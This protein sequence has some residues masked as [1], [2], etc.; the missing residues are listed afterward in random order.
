MA[1][2]VVSTSQVWRPLKIGG[3]GF[4]TKIAS[5]ADGT[6]I[7]RTDTY[8]GYIRRPNDT[9]WTQFKTAYSMPSA[10]VYYASGTSQTSFG[11]YDVAIATTNNDIMYMVSD[12]RPYKSTNGGATW[13]E[14][15]N[16]F[17]TQ[18]DSQMD[19]DA[20][21]GY[22]ARLCSPFMA[23]DPINADV[24][25]LGNGK[26]LY[27][28]LDGGANWAACTG[29]LDATNNYPGVAAVLVDPS[30]STT[31]GRK[32]VVYCWVYGRG[33]YQ[34]TDGG[35]NFSLMGI[36]G[37]CYPDNPASTGSSEGAGGIWNPRDA[38][39]SADG[40]ILV[41][42]QADLWRYRAGA[43]EKQS[44][45]LD[46]VHLAI[47]PFDSNRAIVQDNQNWLREC[48]N[49]NAATMT[50]GSPVNGN[51]NINGTDQPWASYGAE[52]NV[53][54]ANFTFSKTEEDKI[55]AVGGTHCYQVDVPR[56]FTSIEWVVF[57]SG[58]ENLIGIQVRKFPGNKHIY[59]T[60][61]DRGL[62]V[63]GNPEAY[64]Y[65]SSPPINEDARG[66]PLKWGS[67]AAAPDDNSDI[68][69]GL[70]YFG[71]SDCQ[72]GISYDQGKTWT[73]LNL[74]PIWYFMGPPYGTGWNQIATTSGSPTVTISAGAHGLTAGVS[75]VTFVKATAFAGIDLLGKRYL[76]ASTPDANTF[77]ITYATNASSTVA[78]GGGNLLYTTFHES[79]K[80][81]CVDGS[82]IVT[83][84]L[85]NQSEMF[86][87]GGKITI[88]NTTS[89]G[90][91]NLN[92]RQT[93]L[94]ASGNTITFAP[95]GT[96]NATVTNGGGSNFGYYLDWNGGAAPYYTQAVCSTETNWVMYGGATRLP[97]H[98][99]TDAGATWTACTFPTELSDEGWHFNAY[100]QRN[101][102]DSYPNT[103]G[104]F[105]AYHK[106]GGTYRSTDGGANW[107]LRSSE[108]FS[109]HSAGN[110][111]A[112]L[113]CVP[114]QSGHLFW[115]CGSISGGSGGYAGYQIDGRGMFS[116]DGGTTW[117]FIGVAT[118]GGADPGT[119]E[120]GEVNWISIGAVK[121]GS[122]YPTIWMSAWV[123]G[124]YG[125]YYCTDASPTTTGKWTW[126]S[127][128]A[129][130]MGSMEFI[131]G[132]QA[133]P[134]VWHTCYMSTGGSGYFYTTQTDVT[135]R[136]FE[137]TT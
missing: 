55:Y 103:P 93:I 83:A 68:I 52:Q 90:G 27:R 24:V 5:A 32:S 38:A 22:G 111:H 48:L 100:Q 117:D 25:Y 119:N 19:A 23:V 116:T 95:G 36:V 6:L 15:S 66:F 67:G 45:S 30:S 9:V 94:S 29:I 80:F 69:L 132:M 60:C 1:Q 79:N 123:N 8:G 88:Y 26:R 13:V 77:T 39:I 74:P 33:W 129:H 14:I 105:Y 89:I 62:F 20:K 96:A 7:T 91:L 58:I 18:A 3:G 137:I 81:S 87:V 37:P 112:Q 73:A 11:I 12:E 124:V 75:Y 101:I 47:D 102:I 46:A 49:I 59:C 28:T 63:S 56:N 115:S 72:S 31:S 113:A 82:G 97:P 108:N 34:S 114:G 42:D 128:E 16:G 99:T 126:N 17:A 130:P 35:N 106:V 10:D 64:A 50:W 121:P 21:Q 125:I 4:I 120:I 78:A 109:S 57:N 41:A 54:S 107:T 85:A 44:P 136:T 134:D 43:W 133:D 122:S 40:V 127:V 98:Y 61:Y 53:A 70:V 104:T 76:V 135:K 92:G 51:A 131:T 86:I 65:R 84:V 110:W 118:L 71:N 2:T